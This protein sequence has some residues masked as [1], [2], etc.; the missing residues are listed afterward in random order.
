MHRGRGPGVKPTGL[1]HLITGGGVSDLQP[2]PLPFWTP[3]RLLELMKMM[4]TTLKPALLLIDIDERQFRC[5]CLGGG[6]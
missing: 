3:R 1:G 4:K 2:A 6:P 5:V